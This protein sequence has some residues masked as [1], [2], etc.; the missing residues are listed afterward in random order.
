MVRLLQRE[1]G[2]A[3]ARQ[4]GSYRTMVADGRPPI[5]F[6]FH[7]EVTIR[8]RV[9]G[10]IL[11]QQIGLS[12]EEA[13]ELINAASAVIDLV[14]VSPGEDED[15][16]AVYSPQLPDFSGGRTTLLELRRDLPQM[17]SYTGIN[18][19]T[20]IRYHRE[21][22]YTMDGVDY[23]IRVYQDKHRDARGHTAERIHTAMSVPGQRHEM[24]AAPRSRTGELLL[25]CAVASD[26]ISDLGTQ[27]HRSG[28]VAVIATCVAD[29]MIWTAYL[30]NSV[31]LLE[32]ARP[33]DYFGWSEDMTVGH[34]MRSQALANKPRQILL[35]PP[36]DDTQVI[37]I[38][39]AGNAA[40]QRGHSG[41]FQ[42]ASSGWRSGEG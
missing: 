3:V 19:H 14:I 33:L 23:V 11:V 22:L 16:W 24:L 25:I 29:R 17:L 8:P 41:L 35:P 20:R 42:T 30:T 9:V 40:W 10:T 38:T 7:D 28:D 12:L 32:G 27:L 1:L 21:H 37:P 6:A 2:Y 26:R 4:E 18:P 39:A 31:D 36:P 34:L 13:R 15:G 5:T